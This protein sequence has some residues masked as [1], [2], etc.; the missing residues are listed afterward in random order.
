MLENKKVQKQEKET[1]YKPERRFEA[2]LIVP[3]FK[4]CRNVKMIL[5]KKDS[6][7]NADTF[8]FPKAIKD[9]VP[10]ADGDKSYPEEYIKELFTWEEVEAM[11]ECFK[12]W[13]NVET[14]YHTEVD[15]PISN[16]RF[17]VGSRGQGRLYGFYMFDI[18]ENYPLEFD[19]WGYFDLERYGVIEE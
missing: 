7:N 4:G 17:G 10:P 5:F 15:F 9:Y 19:V 8:D 3:R 2:C 1:A 18:S 16:N 6:E 13:D 14:F 11:K 12:H